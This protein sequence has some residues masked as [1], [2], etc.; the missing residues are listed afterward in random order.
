MPFYKYKALHNN[1]RPRYLRTGAI[2]VNP[3]VTNCDIGWCWHHEAV[4]DLGGPWACLGVPAP[5]K[6]QAWGTE[7]RHAQ[8]DLKTK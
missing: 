1:L 4:I 8:L 6:I 3:N 5:R 7:H 2:S